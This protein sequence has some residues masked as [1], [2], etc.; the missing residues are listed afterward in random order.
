V[1]KFCGEGFP[2]FYAT[3]LNHDCSKYNAAAEWLFGECKTFASYGWEVD[4]NGDPL[5]TDCQKVMFANY[6]H[7]PEAMSLF[8]KLYDN[9][10]GM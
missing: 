9:T 7:T 6:Y 3:D 10:D 5:I 2:D 1:R 4:T 8:D